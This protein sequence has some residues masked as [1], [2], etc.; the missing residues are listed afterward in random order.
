MIDKQSVRRLEKLGF[1]VTI[2][3]PSAS[4]HPSTS[5]KMKAQ[6]FLKKVSRT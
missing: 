3:N 2:S 1:T 4:K 5:Y 6:L